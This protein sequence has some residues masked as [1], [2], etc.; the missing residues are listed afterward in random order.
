MFIKII[1]D[2]TPIFYVLSILYYCSVLVKDQMFLRFFQLVK[3]HPRS[4]KYADKHTR[5]LFITLAY[6]REIKQFLY[7]Y[8]LNGIIELPLSKGLFTKGQI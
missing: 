5:I 1:I 8:L 6:A 4:V 7:V 2:I 3:F